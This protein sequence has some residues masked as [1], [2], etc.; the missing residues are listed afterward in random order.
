M[1]EYPTLYMY[2]YVHKKHNTYMLYIVYK[3]SYM[4]MNGVLPI[5][6]WNYM[7][8]RPY[9]DDSTVVAH[10]KV[11]SVVS[12]ATATGLGQDLTLSHRLLLRRPQTYM[13]MYMHM[14]MYVLKNRVRGQVHFQSILLDT[15]M[16]MYK[17]TVYTKCLCTT[18]TCTCTHARSMYMAVDTRAMTI[19]FNFRHI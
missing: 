2:M 17:P 5:H 18:R 6:S 11:L 13:Y 4:Y 8:L 19:I 12:P 3:N 9:G 14:Y 15:Y 10:S 7:Y 1:D 16:Y